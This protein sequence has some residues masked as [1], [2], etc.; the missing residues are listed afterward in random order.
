VTRIDQD[1]IR[2]PATQA[3]FDALAAGGATGWFVG[4]CVRDAVAGRPVAD[5]DIATDAHPEQTMEYAKQ[6]GLRAIPTGID[7]GTVTV[8]SGDIAHEVTT[9][10]RDVETDGRRAVVA[11]A[12]D[13]AE[14]AH[15]RDFTMN[16]L[17]ADRKGL[18]LDPL[19]QGLNDLSAGRLRFI[20]DPR[21]RIREDYL[22]ILRFFRFHATHGDPAL[23]LDPDALAAIA[24]L[25]DGIDLLSRERIGHEM[26]RLLAA[27][28]PAPSVSA[29]AATGILARVLAGSDA[30]GVAPLVHV[31]ETL[32]LEPDAVRRLAVLGGESVQDTLRLPKSRARELGIVVEAAASGQGPM[33]LGYRL[34]RDVALSALAARAAMTGTPPASGLHDAVEQGAS[35]DFPVSA[36]DLMPTWEGP[37][38]GGRLKDLEDRWI[39]S[40]FA[41]SKD[42]L[43]AAD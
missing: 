8:V 15:R 26:T 25:G 11:F 34:G 7:H 22:R 36:S 21:D 32:S 41:L 17:F 1:W 31:E 10:R 13:I 2:N 35:Q 30:R 9:L 14:D 23:G 37:A 40:G 5:V 29:M 4:G 6:S 28:D 3:I 20:D 24:D 38:L 18:V 39:A 42:A 33:E 27:P 16:A 19:G 12:T 43:L